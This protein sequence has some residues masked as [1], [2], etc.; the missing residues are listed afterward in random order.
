MPPTNDSFS[1]AVNAA[2]ARWNTTIDAASLNRPS[3]C[4]VPV[5]R[6]GTPAGSATASTA[7]GSGGAT[8]APRTSA[9]AMPIGGSIHR[10]TPAAAT[11]LTS[12][13]STDRLTTVTHCERIAAQLVRRA[14]AHNSGGRKI[15]SIISAGMC[16]SGSDGK[17]N[18]DAATSVIKT[19]HGN[20]KRSLMA[21]MTTVAN[22]IRVM[23]SRISIGSSY[24]T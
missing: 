16:S 7:T 12:T 20:P 22:N 1:P 15:G 21:T 13:S 14:S 19:G 6:R 11:A 18:A 5:S 2:R 17:K 9:P 10:A 23:I 24:Y 3:I 8:A 4:R